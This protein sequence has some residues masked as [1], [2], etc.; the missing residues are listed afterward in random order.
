MY[1]IFGSGNAKDKKSPEGGIEVDKELHEATLAGINACLRVL[2]ESWE[3]PGE[4]LEEQ[5]LREL[6]MLDESMFGPN[7]DTEAKMDLLLDDEV[8]KQD[9]ALFENPHDKNADVGKALEA[10]IRVLNRRDMGL[11]PCAKAST[12]PQVD[13]GLKPCPK[14]SPKKPTESQE[15]LTPTL[16]AQEMEHEE[17]M[18]SPAIGSPP[19]EEGSPPKENKEEAE[20]A[21]RPSKATVR[22]K[23]RISKPKAS[24]NQKSGKGKALK[25]PKKGKTAKAI[26]AKA[27]AKAKAQAKGE[28]H[29][30]VRRHRGEAFMKA[31]SVAKLQKRTCLIQK[32]SVENMFSRL[33]GFQMLPLCRN[34]ITQSITQLC[35]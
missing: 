24:K 1:Y 3:T 5:G 6:A 32:T 16:E 8:A 26:A 29:V 21:P 28:K 12:Q 19:K 13:L 23:A 33:L 10:G 34:K 22:P 11:K 9:E 17:V 20:P 18:S 7:K 35:A 30:G 31:H 4:T 14:A 25:S 2:P 15:E 27:K